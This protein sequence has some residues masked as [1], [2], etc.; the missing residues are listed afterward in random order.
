MAD[1]MKK[2]W[3]TKY[4]LTT[5]MFQ[6]ECKVFEGYASSG[7]YTDGGRVFARIGKDAFEDKKDA[8]ARVNKMVKAKIRALEAQLAKLRKMLEE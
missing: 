3:I 1:E 6:R 2:F 5:G 4:A 7:N 8:Q